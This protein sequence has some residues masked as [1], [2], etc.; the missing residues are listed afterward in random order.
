M[1]ICLLNFKTLHL[2]SHCVFA[3]DVP[4]LSHLRVVCE[5]EIPSVAVAEKLHLCNPDFQSHLRSAD[6][7]DY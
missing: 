5:V 4:Q 7:A 3:M 2:L 6:F 1:C